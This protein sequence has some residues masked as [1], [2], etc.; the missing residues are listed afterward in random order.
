M[1]DAEGLAIAREAALV[2]GRVAFERLKDPGFHQWKRHRDVVPEGVLA[3]QEAIVD[4]LRRE[5]P[6]DG[7]LAEEGP[8]DEPVQVDAADLWI[9]DP[10][11]G[12]INFAQGMPLM[13]V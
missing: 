8:E 1:D 9:V 7:I 3:V 12:S 2:G 4:A 11:C 6:D 5:R 10:V 13:A